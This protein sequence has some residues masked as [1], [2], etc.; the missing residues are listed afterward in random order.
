MQTGYKWYTGGM[1]LKEKAA[2]M[3]HSD[4]RGFYTGGGRTRFTVC[5]SLSAFIK[6]FNSET[7]SVVEHFSLLCITDRHM[8]PKR[9]T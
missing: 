1:L 4:I 9:H 3:S 7:R 5:L 8:H 2:A 6:R